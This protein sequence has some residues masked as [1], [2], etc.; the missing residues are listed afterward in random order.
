MESYNHTHATT[1]MGLDNTIRTRLCN[2]HCSLHRYT[3][4]PNLRDRCC[5]P[6]FRR[7]GWQEGTGVGATPGITEPIPDPSS[8]R[9]RAGL[10]FTTKLPKKL[11]SQQRKL[12]YKVTRRD[13]QLVYGTYQPDNHTFSV[14]KLSTD[15]YPHPTH[16]TLTIDP[17]LPQQALWWGRE[18]SSVPASARFPTHKAGSSQDPTAI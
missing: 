14:Y 15:G 4:I 1:A 5:P 2:A 7:A 17:H 18:V 8:T 3:Q 13:G 9:G 12:R 16:R 11:R 10:G 6:E